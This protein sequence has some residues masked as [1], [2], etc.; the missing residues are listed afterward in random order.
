MT[1]LAEFSNC[2]RFHR[3]LWQPGCHIMTELGCGRRCRSSLGPR[4][5]PSAGV[6]TRERI[7]AAWMGCRLASSR[8]PTAVCCVGC[9]AAQHTHVWLR[10]T[11]RAAQVV[12]NLVR[13]RTL[14]ARH[15][16][17]QDEARTNEFLY[18]AARGD[19]DRVLQVGPAK[20]SR[21]ARR[22]AASVLAERAAYKLCMHR[23][24]SVVHS[25]LR[26]SVRRCS[27]AGS[28]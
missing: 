15:I 24:S 10:N 7:S 23:E 8:W 22:R 27:R 16:A 3:A 5:H 18:A 11:L 25:R 26:P 1:L 9:E 4:K 2:M 21:T 6:T 17:R 28:T 20:P 19:T 14:V 13:V 12:S